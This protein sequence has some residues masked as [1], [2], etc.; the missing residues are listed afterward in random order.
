MDEF[1]RAVTAEQ[2]RKRKEEER[3]RE[4][5]KRLEEEKYTPE[6]RAEMKRQEELKELEGLTEEEKMMRLMGFGDFNTT[7]GQKVKDNAV[8]AAKGGKAAS[9][10]RT[11]RQYMNRPGGFNRSLDPVADSKGKVQ[12]RKPRAKR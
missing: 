2:L 5:A 7:K 8:G 10:V 6:E 9:S 12:P 3:A 1:G 4:L 11:Y